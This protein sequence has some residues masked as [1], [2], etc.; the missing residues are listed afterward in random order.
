MIESL[1]VSTKEPQLRL[2]LSERLL[3]ATLRRTA[4]YIEFGRVIDPLSYA[5]GFIA[6]L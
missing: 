5:K 4:T 6:F 3:S 1:K 2:V